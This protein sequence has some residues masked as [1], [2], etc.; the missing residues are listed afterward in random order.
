MVKKYHISFRTMNSH[1]RECTTISSTGDKILIELK[2]IR[3]N[4]EVQN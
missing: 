4:D 1:W 2:D 3:L